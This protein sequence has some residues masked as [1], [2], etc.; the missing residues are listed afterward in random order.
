MPTPG[1]AKMETEKPAGLILLE[2]VVQGED[3]DAQT[4]GSMESRES[5]RLRPSECPA[6][7]EAVRPQRR[8]G[9]VRGQRPF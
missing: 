4:E 7:R 5:S 1:Q 9:Q 2:P 8:V 3:E 6:K